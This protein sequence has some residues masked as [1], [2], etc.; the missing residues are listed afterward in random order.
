MMIGSDELVGESGRGE[1]EEEGVEGDEGGVEKSEREAE[2]GVEGDE[3]GDEEDEG[4]EG[5]GVEG[6]EGAEGVEGDEGVEEDEGG[7]GPPPFTTQFGGVH[8]T[9]FSFNTKRCAK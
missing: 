6:V 2:G 5:E 8:R 7:E 4:I 3:G 9:A 1:R